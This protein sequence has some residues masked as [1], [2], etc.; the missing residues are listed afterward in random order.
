[1]CA[2]LKP[3]QR[4]RF[5]PLDRNTDLTCV[6]LRDHDAQHKW[7]LPTA[8]VQA[9]R[10]HHRVTYR[11]SS[12]NRQDL[13]DR[14]Q[15]RAVVAAS[16]L[17]LLTTLSRLFGAN[18]RGLR[19]VSTF[20][21]QSQQTRLLTAL[22]RGGQGAFPR[23]QRQQPEQPWHAHHVDFVLALER[24]GGRFEPSS[25][26]AVYDRIDRVANRFRDSFRPSHLGRLHD[27][28]ERNHRVDAHWLELQ[29]APYRRRRRGLVAP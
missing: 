7:Q 12:C 9:H 4:R 25:V 11:P 17:H 18:E 29:R 23:A 21:G 19:C 6:R 3:L 5:A 20:T 1:M 10:H 22:F 14:R 24:A 15:Q 16:H 26:V 2:E 27:L 13:A 8:T 28:S